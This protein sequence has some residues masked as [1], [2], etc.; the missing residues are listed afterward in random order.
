MF[1]VG[2]RSK[3]DSGSSRSVPKILIIMALAMAFLLAL[4]PIGSVSSSGLARIVGLSPFSGGFDNTWSLNNCPGGSETIVGGVLQTRESSPG[5]DDDHYGFCSAL[6][7]SFPFGSHGDTLPAGIT[8]VSVS[9]NFLDRT[10][11][12]GSRYHI[13]VGL[14]FHLSNGPTQGCNTTLDNLGCHTNSW[15]EVQSRAEN[16]HGAD[17]QTGTRNTYTAGD[18]FGYDTVVTQLSPGQSY[19]FTIGVE[20]QFARAAAAWNIDPTTPHGLSGIEIGTE[21]FRIQQVNVDWASVT[22]TSGPPPSPPTLSA[23]FTYSPS[24]PATG[25]QVTFTASASGGTVPYSFSWN[26]GDGSTGTGSSA[27]HSYVTAGTF[28]I[29][30]TVM[31]SGSPQQTATS[32]QS[33]TVVNPP[34]PALTASFTFSPSN[35]NVGQ[36]V[37]FTGSA[38]GGTPPYSSSWSFGD[39]ATASGS[40]TIY[41]YQAPG[42][43]TV[44][45]TVADSGGQTASS[46]DTVIVSNPPPAA[47]TATF[48]YAPASPLVGRQVMFTASANGGT[49][50]YS[51]SWSFGDGSIN[52]GSTATHVYSSAG[53]FNVT[54]IVTDSGSP[55]Q[56]A[57]SQQSVTIASQPPPPPTGGSRLYLRFQ[58][59][60]FDGAG[61]A[62]ITVNGGIAGTRPNGDIPTNAQVWR[63]FKLNITRFVLS[64]TN[65]VL[66]THI[67]SDCGVDDNL[68]N[69]SIVD[70]NGVVLFSDPN[71]RTFNCDTS[72]TYAFTLP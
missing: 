20:D 2:G 55:Q 15:F 38:S 66:F 13:F 43:Y 7:G 56:T 63:G 40:S 59:F 72:V 26:F 4:A 3:L 24:S 23:S 18:T 31:D 42:S 46:T 34:P 8:T 1:V 67:N 50:P 68:R 27:T 70:Q 6:R 48:S 44:V 32:Q 64:G 62:T 65:T 41:S 35:P 5:G 58:G 49:I 57:N 47:L 11:L 25:E 28:T 10:L 30:L 53:T 45:L 12:S 52:S 21:G 39:S 51:F 69:L 33:I 14:Y 71:V 17:S 37:S 36:T 54:L 61:E 9:L 16:I 22:L 60:D 29:I 19:K